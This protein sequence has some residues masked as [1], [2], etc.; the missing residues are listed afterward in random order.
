MCGKVVGQFEIIQGFGRNADCFG[1]TDTGFGTEAAGVGEIQLQART[2]EAGGGE[3]GAGHRAGL[4]TLF[5]R[6]KDS[7]LEGTLALHQGLALA[8]GDEINQTGAQ[9]RAH[10]PGSGHNV[11]S[12]RLG[13]MLRTGLAITTLAGRLNGDIKRQ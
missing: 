8:R 13:Q 7:I 9:I 5:Q 1:H 4:Q 11:Q 10:L 2:R 6:T 3:F 12:R